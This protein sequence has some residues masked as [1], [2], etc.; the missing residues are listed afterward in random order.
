MSANVERLRAGYA[1]FNKREW[2]VFKDTLTEDVVVEQAAAVFDSA[3]RFE[4][5]EGVMESQRVLSE[6]WDD[7]RY[8]PLEFYEDGDRVLV[9][10]RFSARGHETGIPFEVEIGHLFTMREGRVATLQVFGTREEALTESGFGD[11]AEA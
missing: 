2:D 9:I 8:E 11:D 6:A 10:N 3:P 4:G 1:A 7:L 5:R